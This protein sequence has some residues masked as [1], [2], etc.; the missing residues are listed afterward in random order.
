[1]FL[2]LGLLVGV[3]AS[4]SDIGEEIT[5]FDSPYSQWDGTRYLVSSEQVIPTGIWLGSRMNR[6]FHSPAWQIR[7]VVAC[8]LAGREGIRRRDVLCRFEESAIR[9]STMNAWQRPSDRAIVDKYIGELEDA[10]TQVEVWLRVG[11]SGQVNRVDVVRSA[12]IEAKAVEHVAAQVFQ[13]FNLEI[14]SGG[15]KDDGVWMRGDDPLLRL[16]DTLTTRGN[17][18]TV[19]YSNRFDGHWVV[20]SIGESS[21]V[22]IYDA[23]RDQYPAP[24]GLDRFKKPSE[25]VPDSWVFMPEDRE[26]MPKEIEVPCQTTLHGVTLF[27]LQ[28]QL[29]RERVWTVSGVDIDYWH[30]GQIRRLGESEQVDLGTSGQLSMPGLRVRTV[31]PWTPIDVSK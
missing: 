5:V 30:T 19:H 9:A 29:L 16:P 4:A 18:R 14:P 23:E 17:T 1:M 2:L 25:R 7:A 8:E 24:S 20:Q 3:T 28:S 12:D 13:P 27:E 22:I 6:A 21:T 31:E 15:L 11:D 26:F 10:L